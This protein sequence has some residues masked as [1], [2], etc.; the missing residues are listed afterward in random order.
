MCLLPQ[1]SQS[2]EDMGVGF[3]FRILHQ[4]SNT[5]F[6]VFVFLSFVFSGLHPRHMEVPRLGV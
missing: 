1:V 2:E 4:I 6:F 3:E 5:A